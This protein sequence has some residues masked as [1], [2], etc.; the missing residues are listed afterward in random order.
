MELLVGEALLLLPSNASD[1]IPFSLR[2]ATM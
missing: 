1:S 2:Q